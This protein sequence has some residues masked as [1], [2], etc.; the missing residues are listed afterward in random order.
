[1]I[2]VFVAARWRLRCW[3][4]VDNCLKSVVFLM[5]LLNFFEVVMVGT[6]GSSSVCSDTLGSLVVVEGSGF[7]G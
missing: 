7:K 4:I 5:I 3:R 1:V 2:L 6:L